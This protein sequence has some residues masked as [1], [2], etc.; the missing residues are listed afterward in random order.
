MLLLGDRQE[1]TGRQLRVLYCFLSGTASNEAINLMICLIHFNSANLF[2]PLKQPNRD[3][4]C[5]K[6]SE[7]KSKG[8]KSRIW[9]ALL[10]F[11]KSV[12]TLSVKIHMHS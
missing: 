4:I 1:T 11:S 7:E 8:V 2:N 9:A 12:V 10:Y 5:R 6:K 3:F